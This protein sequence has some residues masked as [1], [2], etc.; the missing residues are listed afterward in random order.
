MNYIYE[1]TNWGI[2]RE[3]LESLCILFTL[4]TLISQYYRDKILE[5][6]N[7][8]TRGLLFGIIIFSSLALIAMQLPMNVPYTEGVVFDLRLSIVILAVS[9]LG[10]K[11]GLIVAL[12]TVC[13]RSLTG[14][15]GAVWWGG[16]AFFLV[17]LAYIIIRTIPFRSSALILAGV[18]TSVAHMGFLSIIALFTNN[19]DYI[20]PYVSP[21]HFIRL[22]LSFIVAM[23]L[24]VWVLDKTLRNIIKFQSDYTTLKIKANIDGLTGKI[25]YR[26]CNELLNELLYSGT[27]YP[28][29]V[30]MIDIDFF[31]KFNDTYGHVEGDKAL[32]K[33]AEA[34]STC[35]RQDDIVA[36]YG[37]EEFV[38]ILPRTASDVAVY[39]AERIRKTVE[40]IRHLDSK[41]TVSIGVA[42][43]IDIDN[44]KVSII[45]DA[46]TQ[47]YAA[48][49]AGRNCV[50]WM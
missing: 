26:H 35:V 24:G 23:T 49:Q 34:I 13:F 21:E 39:I 11:G 43:S 3:L 38:V 30:L 12:F 19:V 41:I 47:M 45:A 50:K 29:S 40:G 6:Q 37:G 46:D 31:K 7:Y 28:L 2:A 14:G 42:T 48:K 17:I 4:I 5:M 44:K 22:S 10:I 32:R 36:R 27:S 16:S 8:S 1:L 15:I 9:Y 33:T 20:S 18:S 25:N